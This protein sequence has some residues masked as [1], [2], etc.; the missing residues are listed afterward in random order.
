M[1]VHD[2]RISCLLTTRNPRAGQLAAQYPVHW[3]ISSLA[4]ASC[5]QA[6]DKDCARWMDKSGPKACPGPG[7]A[8]CPSDAGGGMPW[9][10]QEEVAATPCFC[11][12]L[13]CCERRSTGVER[14]GS[15]SRKWSCGS[16]TQRC[17]HVANR[18]SVAG[19][20]PE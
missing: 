8:I 2:W 7:R 14:E 17:S 1:L 4:W 6:E 9:P 15:H 11:C 19:V 12:T 3:H 10:G 5:K 20:D 18:S 16:L 13:D